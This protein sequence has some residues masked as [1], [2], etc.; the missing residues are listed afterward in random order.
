MDNS[1]CMY[2]IG[3]WVDDLFLTNS[4]AHAQDESLYTVV[5][6]SDSLWYDYLDSE[7]QY[8]DVEGIGLHRFGSDTGLLVYGDVAMEGGVF[9]TGN[10]LDLTNAVKVTGS[11]FAGEAILDGSSLFGTPIALGT[12]H[13]DMVERGSL[14]YLA[15]RNLGDTNITVTYLWVNGT[16]S[17]YS[18]T[19]SGLSGVSDSGEL[20]YLNMTGEMRKLIH[21]DVVGLFL[22]LN[23]TEGECPDLYNVTVSDGITA[24]FE[25][26]PEP[27]TPLLAYQAQDRRDPLAEPDREIYGVDEEGYIIHWLASPRDV[28]DRALHVTDSY[29][30]SRLRRELSV[31][32]HNT[33]V[34]YYQYLDFWTDTNPPLPDPVIS[35]EEPTTTYNY[36][37]GWSTVLE[38][39]DRAPAT[40]RA[41]SLR[42]QRVYQVHYN[43]AEGLNN[44]W[45]VNT[46]DPVKWDAD[47]YQFEVRKY[48]WLPE[49]GLN[50]VIIASF[51]ADSTFIHDT[52]S[53]WQFDMLR[54]EVRY[55][56][57]DMGGNP[58]GPQY[59]QDFSEYHQMDHMTDIAFMEDMAGCT[60]NVSYLVDDLRV[61]THNGTKQVLREDFSYGDVTEMVTATEWDEYGSAEQFDLTEGVNMG[62]SRSVLNIDPEVL[63]GYFMPDAQLEFLNGWYRAG[64]Y[65][66]SVYG[67]FM[68]GYDEAMASWM[69]GRWYQHYA[70]ILDVPAT[71]H[72]NLSLTYPAGL[73][74]D[75]ARRELWVDGRQLSIDSEGQAQAYLRTG[76]H[77]IYVRTF[78]NGTNDLNTFRLQVVGASGQAGFR[79]Y[80]PHHGRMA[81]IYYDPAH[82]ERIREGGSPSYYEDPDAM[83]TKTNVIMASDAIGGLKV[84]LDA[85][86]LLDYMLRDVNSGGYDEVGVPITPLTETAGSVLMSVDAVPDTIYQGQY[87]GSIAERYLEFNGYFTTD[88]NIPFYMTTHE[89][90]TSSIWPR[91]PEYVLDMPADAWFRADGAVKRFGPKD[92]PCTGLFEDK[93]QVQDEYWAQ[94]YTYVIPVNSDEFHSKHRINLT[95]N[96]QEQ[97]LT[98]LRIDAP[99]TPGIWSRVFWKYT[100]E[101]VFIL[102]PGRMQLEIDITLDRA[103]TARGR[104]E[105]FVIS[106]FDVSDTAEP[107]SSSLSARETAEEMS[108]SPDQTTTL[109]FDLGNIDLFYDAFVDHLSFELYIPEVV[110]LRPP[111]YPSYQIEQIRIHKE[112]G[113]R[114]HRGIDE[115]ASMVLPMLDTGILT[116]LESQRRILPS[117]TAQ[118]QLLLERSLM[119]SGRGGGAAWHDEMQATVRNY[120]LTSLGEVELR[121]QAP[122]TGMYTASVSDDLVVTEVE[123]KDSDDR[124]NP[125]NYRL[126]FD[127]VQSV[128]ASMAYSP[129]YWQTVISE[130][131]AGTIYP[132]IVP[133]LSGDGKAGSWMP[134]MST[135]L[136]HESVGG[137]ATDTGKLILGDFKE[138][139]PLWS[140][141][142]AY[143]KESG[144]RYLE[145][146][147]WANQAPSRYANP[148]TFQ[149]DLNGSGI[150]THGLSQILTTNH[151]WWNA[152]RSEAYMD[153]IARANQMNVWGHNPIR[154]LI[155]SVQLDY[156]VE[157]RLERYAREGWL[158]EVNAQSAVR[159]Y[160]GVEQADPSRDEWWYGNNELNWFVKETV[161]D[162]NGADWYE[163]GMYSNSTAPLNHP[164]AASL[165][166]SNQTM[167]VR[168]TLQEY[169]NWDDDSPDAPLNSVPIL[170]FFTS[171]AV[172]LRHQLV[173]GKDV[174]LELDWPDDIPQDETVYTTILLQGASGDHWTNFTMT[175]ENTTVQLDLREICEWTEPEESGTPGLGAPLWVSNNL[176]LRTV[177][178]LAV[179]VYRQDPTSRMDTLSRIRNLLFADSLYLKMEYDHAYLDTYQEI[180]TGLEQDAERLKPYMFALGAAMMVCAP[181]NPAMA[182][183]GLDMISQSLWETSVWDVAAHHVMWGINTLTRLYGPAHR[184]AFDE[185]YI[186]NFSL[187]HITH[188]EGRN[189]FLQEAF[190][191]A[192]SFVINFGARAVAHE[193]GGFLGLTDDIAEASSR[194][195]RFAGENLYDEIAKTLAKRESRLLKAGK[196]ALSVAGEYFE[197]VGE[198]IFEMAFDNMLRL[199][200]SE[201]P[202]GGGEVFLTLMTMY[203]LT[204]AGLDGELEPAILDS[205]P[206]SP[207]KRYLSMTS[208]AL[209]MVQLASLSP[210]LMANSPNWGFWAVVGANALGPIAMYRSWESQAMTELVP[211]YEVL[212]LGSG[213]YVLIPIY[214]LHGARITG[215]PLVLGV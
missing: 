165:F 18:A 34:S 39:I 98:G 210:V 99:D 81:A 5:K 197:L 16:Q 45:F 66:K 91:G 74:L 65:N 112:F 129:F 173:R 12:E 94:E 43:W 101:Y 157:D 31:N 185:N 180:T 68:A 82:M 22:G 126:S 50:P 47:L 187:F 90:G 86:D 122:S 125:L 55:G 120:Q 88:G 168:P 108:F 184:A 155:S 104:L 203:T 130:N 26:S 191:E 154:D 214:H 44:T 207:A 32:T 150:L 124:V 179:M 95:A 202:M 107:I 145:Y 164:V 25:T 1:T 160:P 71:G 76:L 109:R 146:G 213:V 54:G 40:D 80:V 163:E 67:E 93:E 198:V 127:P 151:A 209:L 115:S 142:T 62:L 106:G 158:D 177:P 117:R 57:V 137:I 193:I 77:T 75:G 20:Y 156:T 85:D 9:S 70:T 29:D 205:P 131:D 141:D 199:D 87:S 64:F 136:T 13:L 206:L 69:G 195:S 96:S 212:P 182:V 83:R 21:L 114:T 6:A 8:S 118:A 186:G 161:P 192:L 58:V 211:E 181:A 176:S 190:S 46:R 119:R 27:L 42:A 33:T 102:A 24:V 175:P 123:F 194:F 144:R 169:S 116:A 61:M 30:P 149:A 128:S 100:P 183:W 28:M 201:R 132:N 97:S 171:D 51:S 133:G 84:V 170:N 35:E 138:Y 148:V 111:L 15:D 53:E 189:L 17:P 52:W 134:V 143:L 147:T 139:S 204:R 167:Q 59:I 174:T 2:S 200:E 105:S 41:I 208:S 166:V 196:V 152:S 215:L 188:D 153:Y 48:E 56:E 79:A 78:A 121:S 7:V 178:A 72:Y 49:G 73:G 89:D 3:M 36:A 37:S 19:V 23:V 113:V 60:G 135:T 14:L 4:T 63:A 11:V 92:I 172:I 162:Y 159:R 10:P 140:V 103:L 110:A 38:L